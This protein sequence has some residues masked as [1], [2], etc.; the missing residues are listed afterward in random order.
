MLG[1]WVV[2]VAGRVSNHVADVGVDEGDE[3][4]SN[5]AKVVSAFNDL[6]AKTRCGHTG[7][8]LGLLYTSD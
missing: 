7:G 2:E 1:D 5:A 4:S 8:E 6:S 3:A